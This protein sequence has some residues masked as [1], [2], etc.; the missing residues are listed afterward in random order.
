MLKVLAD[1]KSLTAMEERAKMMRK[2]SYLRRKEKKLQD[3]KLAKKK[4]A[5]KTKRREAKARHKAK[6]ASKRKADGE[7]AVSG[8]DSAEDDGRASKKRKTAKGAKAKPETSKGKN[9]GKAKDDDND[10]NDSGSS[11]ESGES[12]FDE[13]DYNQV[14]A[15]VSSDESDTAD[16]DDDGD[17]T[18]KA[19][20]EV[21][22]QL[23]TIDEDI[24][25]REELLD[26]RDAGDVWEALGAIP[27]SEEAA[28]H[29]EIR[30]RIK[31]QE[32]YLK[33]RMVRREKIAIKGYVVSLP[34]DAFQFN[35]IVV[36]EAQSLRNMESGFS[37]IIRLLTTHSRAL[38]MMSATPTL[39][40]ID[41]IRS[42][43]SLA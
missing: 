35:R 34:L 29:D 37:R 2:R 19:L 39:N 13:S 20:N 38:H 42:L 41:D 40:K 5:E 15:D 14:D 18:A 23:E 1:E 31:I 8:G 43:G 9:K 32:Q 27:T 16:E 3:A 30:K 4:E 7:D 36:D 17:Q 21:L 6:L 28:F 25:E 33:E 26:A 24:Q 10:D 22:N 11:S 12:D